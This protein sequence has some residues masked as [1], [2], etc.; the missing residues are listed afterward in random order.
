MALLASSTKEEKEKVSSGM[1]GCPVPVPKVDEGKL[2]N[3][4]RS[5]R[6][7]RRVRSCRLT[8]LSWCCARRKRK[9]SRSEFDTPPSRARVE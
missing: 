1:E 3:D 9:R 5:P 4:C 8:R 2:L 7:P 6:S